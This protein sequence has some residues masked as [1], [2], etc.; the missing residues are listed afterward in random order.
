MKGYDL[1]CEPKLLLEPR[2]GLEGLFAELNA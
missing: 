2:V 1:V